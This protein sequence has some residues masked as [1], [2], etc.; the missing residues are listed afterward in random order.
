MYIAHALIK[1]VNSMLWTRLSVSTAQKMK[2]SIKNIFS[3]C[4]QIRK[5]LQIWSH[6]L[7]KPLMENVIFCEVEHSLELT[8]NAIVISTGKK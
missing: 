7:K 6:L 2:F 8:C 3:Y 4:D 5:K 1:K